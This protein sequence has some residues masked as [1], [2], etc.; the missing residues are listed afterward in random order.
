MIWTNQHNLP[1][2]MVSLVKRDKYR[3]EKNKS[4][5]A[6]RKL[7]SLSDSIPCYSVTELIGPVQKRSLLSRW[8]HKVVKDVSSATSMIIG[9]ALHEVLRAAAVE[10]NCE[11]K[12]QRYTPE[13]RLFAYIQTGMG[14]AIVCG[15]PDLID[16]GEILDYKYCAVYAWQNGKKEWDSQLNMYSWLQRI[17]GVGTTKLTVNAFLRD[18]SRAETVKEGYPPTEQC[19]R[20]VE[21]WDSVKQNDF[22]MERVMAHQAGEGVSD[23]NLA[24]QMPCTPEEMWER[25]ESWAVT[26]EGAAKAYRVIR[27]AGEPGR[28]KAF[29]M[30]TKMGPNYSVEHRLGE[31][32]RCERG[33]CDASQFCVQFKEYRSAAWDKVA[34]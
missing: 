13:V 12:T 15:E 9:S 33:Y 10:F 24:E 29:D 16:G 25:P 1:E 8:A 27:E 30:A 28:V 3:E 19:Q 6:F 32:I 20:S 7:H 11:N 26:K 34:K 2:F 23:G 17:N 5:N 14:R 31:R 4:L 18:W 22:V 21:L